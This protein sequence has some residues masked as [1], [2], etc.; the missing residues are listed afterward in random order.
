MTV[1][2]F[3]SEN[4]DFYTINPYEHDELPHSFYSTTDNNNYQQWTFPSQE[5]EQPWKENIKTNESEVV[6]AV[7]PNF[8]EEEIAQERM[9]I[10]TSIKKI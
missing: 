7:D 10:L 3:T 8:T 9:K 2:A 5:I 1:L 6:S 4:I